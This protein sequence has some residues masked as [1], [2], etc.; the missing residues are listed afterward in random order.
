ML[1]DLPFQALQSNEEHFL[2]EN[3]TVFYAPSLTALRE[4]LNERNKRSGSAAGR[5][6]LLALGNPVTGRALERA[7]TGL[8]DEN[9]EPLPEAEDK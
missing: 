5:L 6:D 4:M 7:K 8:L 1:W 3:H 2:I 9:L